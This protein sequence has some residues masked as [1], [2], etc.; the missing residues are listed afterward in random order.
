VVL[1][2]ANLTLDLCEHSEPKGERMDNSNLNVDKKETLKDIE[3]FD[4]DSDSEATEPTTSKLSTSARAVA[5]RAKRRKDK[6]KTCVETDESDNGMVLYILDG[7]TVV[8]N[9]SAE[10]IGLASMFL[11]RGGVYGMLVC[12][13]I[14]R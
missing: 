3:K 6:I 2:T 14:L 9:K 13:N 5:A 10:R 8:F 11:E 7:N 4:I 1:I 12:N